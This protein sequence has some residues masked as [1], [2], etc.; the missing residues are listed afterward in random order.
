MTIN[1]SLMLITFIQAEKKKPN[2]SVAHTLETYRRQL[3]HNHPLT[4][5]QANSLKRIYA[6]AT[7]GGDYEHHKRV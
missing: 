4:V 2:S 5:E 6:I 1:D 7:G 3:L